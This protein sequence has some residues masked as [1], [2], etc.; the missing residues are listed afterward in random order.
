MADDVTDTV[1]QIEETI[2]LEQSK[3]K[4]K[5]KSKRPEGREQREWRLSRWKTEKLD[6]C[7]AEGP[8]EAMVLP[9][10]ILETIVIRTNS[11]AKMTLAA[12]GYR[13]PDDKT[14]DIISGQNLSALPT[15]SRPF[16]NPAQ[17]TCAGGSRLNAK[18]VISEPDR[19]RTFP[20]VSPREP[21]PSS[22]AMKLD[23]TS[24]SNTTYTASWT[25]TDV[26]QWAASPVQSSKKTV[27][28]DHP[29]W[30]RP[31]IDE[32]AIAS[33]L[34]H[35]RLTPPDMMTAAVSTQKNP[36][37]GPGNRIEPD[38]FLPPIR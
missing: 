14:S 25:A 34:E 20:C 17:R 26:P 27:G 36:S 30:Q 10:D 2:L 29:T 35:H 19:H 1:P 5:K 6:V 9:V 13:G 18:T 21:F 16:S 3:L 4:S 22:V 12:A 24:Q 33:D 38:F 23:G 28:A 8:G 15:G 11:A 32:D 31:R 7:A 37:S